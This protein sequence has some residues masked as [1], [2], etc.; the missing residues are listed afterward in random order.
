MTNIASRYL[1]PF[2]V[3]VEWPHGSGKAT[4]EIEAC[5]THQARQEAERTLRARFRD[6]WAIADCYI[7]RK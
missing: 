1:R 7:G 5:N 6:G 3:E 2:T 4:L